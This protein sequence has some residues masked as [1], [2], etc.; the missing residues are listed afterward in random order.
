MSVA[1]G[2]TAGTGGRQQKNLSNSP[3]A[4]VSHNQEIKRLLSSAIGGGQAGHGAS[5]GGGS[6]IS[7]KVG[8]GQKSSQGKQSTALSFSGQPVHKAQAKT[9][10][11]GVPAGYTNLVGTYQSQGATGSSHGMVTSHNYQKPLIPNASK[12][13]ENMKDLNYLIK[14]MEKFSKKKANAQQH[15]SV[16]NV[17]SGSGQPGQQP[18]RPQI[19]T[20]SGVPTSDPQTPKD[21]LMNL[22]GQ[23]MEGGASRQAGASQGA[24]PGPVGAATAAGPRSFSNSGGQSGSRKVSKHKYASLLQQ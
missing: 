12:R 7:Q 15:G 21:I 16:T 20:G 3:K 10:R 18:S 14:T 13:Q 2:G 9:H 17:E 5:G 6:T 19:I 1:S 4:R 24:V 11:G 23:M 22:A 8:R